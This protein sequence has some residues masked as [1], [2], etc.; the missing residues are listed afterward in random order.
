[1]LPH[2]GPLI[3][4]SP[5]TT[6]EKLEAMKDILMT[7]HFYNKDLGYVLGMSDLLAPVL[8]VLEDEVPSF[9]RS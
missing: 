6:N 2:P 8:I 4:A 5:K 1:N 7:Y 3:S 9:L